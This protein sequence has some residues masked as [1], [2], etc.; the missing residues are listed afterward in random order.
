[1]QTDINDTVLTNKRATSNSGTGVVYV[2]S[3]WEGGTCAGETVCAMPRPSGSA[4]KAT[5][6]ARHS[7]HRLHDI[8]NYP[9]NH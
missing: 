6:H 2:W 9:Q 1:M 5:A 4:S 8:R 7:C 3:A